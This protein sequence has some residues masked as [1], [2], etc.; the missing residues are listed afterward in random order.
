MS[1]ITDFGRQ[2][3]SYENDRSG[4]DLIMGKG[5]RYFS[6]IFCFIERILTEY[7]DMKNSLDSQLQI[8]SIC[9]IRIRSRK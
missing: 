6:K 9:S 2:M 4:R 8:Y 7:I 1:L 5:D 3:E